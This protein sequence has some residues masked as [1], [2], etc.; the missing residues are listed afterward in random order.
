MSNRSVLLLLCTEHK[1][2]NS[3]PGIW[4][5]LMMN[6]GSI[7]VDPMNGKLNELVIEVYVESMSSTFNGRVM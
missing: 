5:L 2:N 3:D 6:N 4:V 7:Y 1:R